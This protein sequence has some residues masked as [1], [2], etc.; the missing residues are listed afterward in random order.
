MVGWFVGWLGA[1]EDCGWYT[2]MVYFDRKSL[3]FEST[4]NINY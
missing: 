4:T 1:E 2:Q 3:W